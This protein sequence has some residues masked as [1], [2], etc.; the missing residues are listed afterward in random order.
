VNYQERPDEATLPPKRCVR[1]DGCAAAMVQMFRGAGSGKGMVDDDIEKLLIERDTFADCRHS[2][3][4]PDN[5]N[6]RTCGH[7]GGL[8]LDLS[9]DAEDALALTWIVP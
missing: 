7:D 6:V 2:L 4:L 8:V 9:R 1:T 5:H 3:F